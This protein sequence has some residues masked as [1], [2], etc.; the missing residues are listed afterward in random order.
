MDEPLL[1]CPRFRMGDRNWSCAW[2][3]CDRLWQQQQQQQQQQ[4]HQ[5]QQRKESKRWCGKEQH[6]SSSQEHSQGSRLSNIHRVT[7]HQRYA[8]ARV[9]TH[10]RTNT[11]S[12]VN[13]RSARHKD[14]VYIDF[15]HS[16]VMTKS[17]F[18]FTVRISASSILSLVLGL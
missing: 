7:F 5:Q 4:R 1:A 12:P 18:Q 6:R 14:G 11:F 15:S 9:H 2:R 8:P 3:T 16:V 17:A 10:T 13:A